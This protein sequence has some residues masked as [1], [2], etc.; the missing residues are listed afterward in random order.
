MIVCYPNCHYHFLLNLLLLFLLISTSS[1]S[2]VLAFWQQYPSSSPFLSK[3]L[4]T[5]SNRILQPTSC[6]TSQHLPLSPIKNC[7]SINL[8]R[9]VNKNANY[10]SLIL[11]ANLKQEDDNNRT[12]RNN[13]KEDE[14]HDTDKPSSSFD[15]NLIILRLKLNK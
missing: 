10:Q 3:L 5:C 11:A 15:K 1:D 4:P 9:N 7:L 13:P 6:T 2:N 8:L 12:K 14:N